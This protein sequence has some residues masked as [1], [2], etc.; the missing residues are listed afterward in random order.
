M[1]L[2]A[3]NVYELETLSLAWETWDEMS[4]MCI[5]VFGAS[6]LHCRWV[7]RRG[8]LHTRL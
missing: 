7:F 8:A 4:E 3:S 6:G 2:E 5:A 1:L